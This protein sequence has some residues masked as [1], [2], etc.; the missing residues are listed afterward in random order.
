MSARFRWFLV[1]ASG[2]LLGL[3]YPPLP[4]PWLAW[5][6]FIPLLMVVRKADWRTAAGSAFVAHLLA[7]GIAGYWVLLHPDGYTRWA[8]GAGMIWLALLATLPWAGA[9]LARHPG[10]FPAGLWLVAGV[11]SLEMFHLYAEAGFPWQAV[12]HTQSSFEPFNQLAEYGGVVGLSVWVL[13]I[14]LAVGHSV[15]AVG[16]A[17]LQ[18]ALVALALVVVPA[19][20]G[21]HRIDH[22]ERQADTP[23]TP[24]RV[25]AVQPS[26]P[27]AAWLDA[28]SE[29]R[30]ESLVTMTDTAFDRAASKARKI[31]LVVWPET[32]LPPMD[33]HDPSARHRLLQLAADWDAPV[34]SGAIEVVSGEGGS[35]FRN[36]AVLIDSST[37]TVRSYR[38]QRL[39]PFAEHVPYSTQFPFLHRLAVPSGGV[40]GYAPGKKDGLFDLKTSRL[41]V[42][43]CFE[44]VIGDMA[45]RLVLADAS[46]IAIL[47]QDGWWGDTFGYRQHLAFNRLRAIETRRPV[48]QVAATGITAQIRPSGR[49]ENRLGWMERS[50]ASLSPRPRHGQ[51]I[52]ARVGDWPGYACL[53]L[54]TLLILTAPFRTGG[55]EG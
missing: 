37:D 5:I 55:D 12:G 53:I 11:G 45:R 26:L 2:A 22:F 25:L 51:T 8:S 18:R 20:I 31:D 28:R 6:A 9:T 40:W 52:Y 48:L 39:V 27:V 10:S 41:G 4:F 54:I 21:I 23:V 7:Y 14:N 50:S 30:L 49:I 44:S 15:A 43:I 47:T 3:S 35:R 32:A 1:F 33:L 17:R 29:A 38:K 46:V 19:L 36:A 16:R 13:M 34:L 42:L 24:L